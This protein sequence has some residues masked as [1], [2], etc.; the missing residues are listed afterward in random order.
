MPLFRFPE[1]PLELRAEAAALKG[2]EDEERP[3][4]GVSPMN[5]ADLTLENRSSGD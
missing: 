1:P 2:E 3:Q 5:V 4:W